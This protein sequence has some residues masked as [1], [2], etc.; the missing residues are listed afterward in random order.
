[1]QMVGSPTSPFGDDRFTLSTRGTFERA[2]ATNSPQ[3]WST[4]NS[5]FDFASAE[6]CFLA[7]KLVV[8]RRSNLD[9]FLSST[10][11]TLSEKEGRL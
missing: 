1:M 10:L 11:S 3:A 2:A 5:S 4:S 6:V 9:I 7:E 8:L